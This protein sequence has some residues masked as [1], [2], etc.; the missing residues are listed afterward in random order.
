MDETAQLSLFKF[1]VSTYDTNTGRSIAGN[2]NLSRISSQ[3]LDR[4]IDVEVGILS[5]W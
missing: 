2:Q 4:R 1:D 3:K 5:D